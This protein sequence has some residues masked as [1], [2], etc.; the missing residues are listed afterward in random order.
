MYIYIYIYIY[1]CPKGEEGGDLRRAD[2]A[3]A[4]LQP[5]GAPAAVFISST[6]MISSSS[7]SSSMQC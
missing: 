4:R 1:T 6:I 2:A 3:S 7:S 5:S